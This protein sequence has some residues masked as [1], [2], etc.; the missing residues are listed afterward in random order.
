MLR[1]AGGRADARH[2]R[3]CARRPCSERPAGR[4]PTS[5]STRLSSESTMSAPVKTLV[6]LDAGVDATRRGGAPGR[7]ASTSWASS[8]GLEAGWTALER[9]ATDALLVAAGRRRRRALVHPGAARQ[10][11]TGRCRPLTGA[12][13]R[14]R[15][16]GV[17][18]PAPTTSS[19]LPHERPAASD[20]DGGAYRPSSVALEKAVAR[21]AAAASG[22]R[23]DER[24][25]DLRPRAQGRHRQDAR[26][27][28]NLAVAL[29]EAGR[30]G[31][32]RRPRPPVRRRRA[33]ARACSPT[34]RSTTS[35]VGRLARRR[36]GRRLPASRTT[37]GCGC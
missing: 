36:E 22:R 7:P 2:R 24:P 25:H 31:R 29:A 4:A 23:R 34:A 13:A 30:A 9:Q 20:D 18:R 32:P 10:S 28:A 35:P 37:A 5:T 1:P 17:R 6:A 14:V 3:R 27:R 19:T 11:P 16:G 33:G 8:D 12:P 21:R 26:R 15:A